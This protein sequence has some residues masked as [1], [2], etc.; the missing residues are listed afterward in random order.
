MLKNRGILPLATLLVLSGSFILSGCKENQ[1]TQSSISI[2]DVSVVTLKAEP[3]TV[4]TELPGRTTAY[5]V[6]E[7]RP[8]VSGIILKRNYKEGSDIVAGE[9]L[10]QIDPAT[11]QAEYSK[12]KA[13]LTRAQANE[14]VSHLTVERYKSLL[15]TQYVSKQEF[16]KANSDYAQA[17]ADVQSAHAA[18]ESARINLAYTKVT[19][20][21]SGRAGKSTVTEGALVSA[22]QGTALTTVQQLDPIYVD[23]T[24]SSDDY[25]KLKDEIAKGTIKKENQKTKIRLITD[26]GKE[27]SKEGYLEFSDVTVDETTSSI[28]MRAVFPNP[29][30]ELLPGMFVRTKLEEGVRKNAILIPQEAVART[31]RGQATTMIVDKDNRV[32]LRNINAAQAIG[33]KWLVTDGVSA[34]DKVIVNRLQIIAP[35][36]TVNP[37]EQ[38]LNAKPAANQT[39][40]EKKPQ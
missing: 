17:N 31:A 7:V 35:G 37:K 10:Y 26:T 32:E 33:N 13:N 34:G 38:D 12:A 1:E 22:G 29:N 8:Q 30:E 16:D 14:K 25:L 6:A 40:T 9:S 19:S 27:Y 28:T 11:Y 39:E 2:L 4:I 5:R 18:L 23:I 3:L 24:Q 36:M 20:P 21:I 15:G